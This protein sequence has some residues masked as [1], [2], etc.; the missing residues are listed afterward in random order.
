MLA[1]CDRGTLP[2]TIVARYFV[3]INDESFDPLRSPTFRN[4]RFFL[5]AD[6]GL[7][8]NTE[9]PD[10]GRLFRRTPVT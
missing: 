3:L 8:R 10:A 6:R 9:R 5:I 2:T 4:V 1:I 7:L